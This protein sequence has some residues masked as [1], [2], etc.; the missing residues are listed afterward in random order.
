MSLCIFEC[1]NI[2]FHVHELTETKATCMG[3]AEV[4][5]RWGPRAERCGYMPPLLTQ[6]NPKMV[7]TNKKLVFSKGVLLGKQTNP[8]G[9]LYAQQ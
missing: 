1:V 7:A 2:C 9:K 6:S 5:T 3:P 8:K 4:C